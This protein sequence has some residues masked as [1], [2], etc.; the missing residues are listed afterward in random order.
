MHTSTEISSIS[1]PF[2]T[3]S[4]LFIFTLSEQETV[5]KEHILS[6][7]AI[8]NME[9]QMSTSHGKLEVQITFVTRCPLTTKN[10][11]LEKHVTW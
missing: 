9:S 1:M 4:M 6:L 8:N 10:I 7:H 3:I 2:K 11:H 5:N